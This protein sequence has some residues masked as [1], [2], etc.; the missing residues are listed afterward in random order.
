MP[1]KQNQLQLHILVDLVSPLQ[2]GKDTQ[3]LQHVSKA[4]KACIETAQTELRD[5][6]KQRDSLLARI[7]NFVHDSVPQSS[8][9]VWSL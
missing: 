9:E 8:D 3:E 4:K 6:Q 1:L 5:L 2:A 7:G